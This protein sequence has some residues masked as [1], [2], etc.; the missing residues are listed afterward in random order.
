MLDHLHI[1]DH[2]EL[3]LARRQKPLH[4]G[5]AIIDGEAQRFPMRPRRGDIFL[6]CVDAR[7][8]KPQA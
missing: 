1:Q 8:R 5:G 2:V 6:R 4:R 3:R 7:H